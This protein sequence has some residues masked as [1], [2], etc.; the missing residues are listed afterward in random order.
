VINKNKKRYKVIIIIPARIK[1]LRLRKKLLK[2]IAGLPM[3]VRVA[4]NAE[5]LKIGRVIVGTDSLEI[6]NVCRNEGI[7]TII[8]K[9][10]HES[11]TDR[12]QE[13]FEVVAK[14]YDLIANL[15]G[16]LPI[17]NKDLFSKTISLFSDSS[18]D[19]G[20]AVCELDNKEMDDQNIV[21]AKVSLDKNDIGFAEDFKRIIKRK[22]DHYHHIGMY[23]YRPSILEKFVKLKQSKKEKERK[24]E[25]MRALENKINIKLVKISYNPPSVDTQDDLRKIR[26]IFKKNNL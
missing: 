1:S 9:R 25:Q 18:V 11:G 16:D 15:Q 12:V 20:S 19:I 21:K 24:L 2:N 22:K 3:I 4:K 14:D 17:F 23:I 10:K 8:T 13:V 26:L 5:S 7:E 6:F